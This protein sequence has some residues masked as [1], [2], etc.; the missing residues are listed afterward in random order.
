MKPD[1]VSLN[2]KGL[3]IIPLIEGEELLKEIDL[4]SNKIKVIENLVSIPSMVKVNLS[5]N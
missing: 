1:L 3:S 2:G 5:N 4:S